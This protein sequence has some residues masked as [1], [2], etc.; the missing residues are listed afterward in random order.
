MAAWFGPMLI[1]LVV[2][3]ASFV[4]L[5]R[6][7]RARG[8]IAQR[9][10]SRDSESDQPRL[11]LGLLDL[12]S[13]QQAGPIVPPPADLSAVL[14]AAGY[15]QPSA[16]RTYHTI[17][18]LLVVL[19]LLAMGVVAL[20]VDRA[21]LMAVVTGGMVA[22]GLGYSLPRAYLTIRGANRNRQ[23]ERGLPMA[24]DLLTLC[25]SAGENL[26][27][28]LVRVCH[29]LHATQPALAQELAIVQ[30]QA[31]LRSLEHALQ[32]L[33]NRVRVPE[34]RNL[35]LLLIQAE[36]LGTDIASAL[37]EFS[38]SFRT[39]LRQ[40]AEA[41]A[42]RA[43]FWMLL[44]TVFCLWIA[45]AIILIGPAYLE[46]WH[47]RNEAA[48]MLHEATNNVQKANEPGPVRPIQPP[49]ENKAN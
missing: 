11:L 46:F 47:L 36:R 23:L 4:G 40:R 14:R 2:T 30:R 13:E 24:V 1:F 39:T 38:S 17:R 49:A 10:Q 15:Y 29:E 27:S 12:E 32:Q 16:H 21:H 9:L 28:A 25:L 34:V 6:R 8:H 45:A 20:L 41:H 26:L 31:E 18:T 22:A 19:P 48:D 5:A 37:L 43:S 7:G 42:N 3:G 35:A 44:P 33:A